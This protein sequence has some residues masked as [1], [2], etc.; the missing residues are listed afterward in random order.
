MV[1]ARIVTLRDLIKFYVKDFDPTYDKIY[2][3]KS[4]KGLILGR[5][6]PGGTPYNMLINIKSEVFT[7]L[8]IVKYTM[9]MPDDLG[10][11]Y[12]SNNG[13]EN[14]SYCNNK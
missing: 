2:C 11:I 6:N 3:S 4:S 14:R 5:Q 9:V 10:S 12:G 8:D 13:Y 7:G 1:Q